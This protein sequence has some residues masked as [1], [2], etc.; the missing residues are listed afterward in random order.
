[1]SQFDQ[2]E[3][4]NGVKC[5]PPTTIQTYQRFVIEKET[6]SVIFGS[7]V[8]N[9]FETFS[10][11][12]KI[13]ARIKGKSFWTLFRLFVESWLLPYN[14]PRKKQ[15]Q[16]FLGYEQYQVAFHYPETKLKTGKKIDR[17]YYFGFYC[18]IS[19]IIY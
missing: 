1:M 5:F 3:L 10:T 15:F 16:L 13:M 4:Q 19:S 11:S 14:F 7:T 12:P 9:K 6:S 17:E 18:W 2:K 8:S